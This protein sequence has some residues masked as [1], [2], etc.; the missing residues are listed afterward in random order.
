MN[1]SSNDCSYIEFFINVYFCLLHCPLYTL[2]NLEYTN[3]FLNESGYRH[4]EKELHPLLSRVTS[5][6]SLVTCHSRTTQRQ[7]KSVFSWDFRKWKNISRYKRLCTKLLLMCTILITP[8]HMSFRSQ[9]E[10]ISQLI[11]SKIAQQL[12]LL[13]EGSLNMSW[14]CAGRMELSYHL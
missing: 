10:S 9:A 2:T 14:Y 11:R 7:P 3:C 13:W 4:C 8:L 12:D 5:L 1:R 6:Y